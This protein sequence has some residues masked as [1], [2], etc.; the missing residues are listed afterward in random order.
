MTEG[1]SIPKTEG[2]S[3]PMT[4]GTSGTSFLTNAKES[5]QAPSQQWELVS[6]SKE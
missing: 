5:S 3:I 6:N 4:E 1:T 2:K